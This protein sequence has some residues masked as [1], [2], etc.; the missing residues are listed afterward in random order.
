MNGLPAL[1][2][3][4]KSM[5]RPY[6][7]PKLTKYNA[8]SEAPENIRAVLMSHAETKIFI[9]PNGT[10]QGLQ[11]AR[12]GRTFYASTAKGVNEAFDKHACQD[13]PK[14]AAGS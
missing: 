11:C 8:L 6:S 12:C 5:K 3:W 13:R 10:M 4:T 1:F 7:S 14:T 9:P 2:L